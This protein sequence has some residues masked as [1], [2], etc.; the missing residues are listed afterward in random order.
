MTVMSN[1]IQVEMF[2]YK[3]CNAPDILKT[4]FGECL[5]VGAVHINQGYLF[6][7]PIIDVDFAVNELQNILSD[8]KNDVKNIR[9]L[10]IMVAGLLIDD[11]DSKD[12][13]LSIRQAT[14][15]EIARY[16]FE[17]K[18]ST[19]WADRSDIAYGM[20]VDPSNQSISIDE[21]IIDDYYCDD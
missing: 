10:K 16:S 5:V 13:T 17:R 1:I 11:S 14:L 8:L 4:G 12:T 9:N 20:T 3:K 18:V 21:I 6:H 19:R 2:D 15:S 7:Y